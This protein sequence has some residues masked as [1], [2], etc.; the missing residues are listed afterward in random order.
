MRWLAP[1]LTI[2][3]LALV[4]CMG[5]IDPEQR[6]LCGAVAEALHPDGTQITMRGA[7]PAALGR[8][9]LRLDYTAREPDDDEA[10]PHYVICGFAGGAFDPD[11]GDLVAVDTDSGPLGEARFIYLKRFGLTD[12][13]RTVATQ[14]LPQWPF[15]LAYAAQ[16][17]VSG[18][19]LA[20]IYALLATAYA[21]IYGLVGRLN[22][23][24][25]QIAVM[26]AFW[27]IGGVGAAVAFGLENPAAGLA[28]ALVVAAGLAAGWSWV[29]GA[30]VIAP[31]HARSPRSQP[32]LVATVA[33]AVTIEEG[34]RLF[35]G[36]RDHWVPPTFSAPIGLAAAGRFVVTVTPMQIGIALAAFGAAIAVLLLLRRSRFGRNWRAFADDP[37][38]AAL[39][40]VAPGRVLAGTFLLAGL[41][42]GLAGWI[43][44][45]Y[46]GNVSAAMS[47]MLGL[48]A[49]V[50]AVVGGIGSVPGAFVGGVVIGL[51]EAFW[52][53]YFDIGMRD[54]VVY[55]ILIAIFVLRPG[56]LFG[57]SGPRP[58]DV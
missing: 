39:L 1:I 38:A 50:A 7:Q 15:S 41:M 17:V 4:G 5:S 58:R 23:A 52:S 49:L 9:G 2:V 13:G 43:M 10:R 6:L 53:A 22:L 8:Q 36:V 28:V 30:M 11:R 47:T 16:Q 25:G 29:V 40:G 26:G 55:A 51:V 46:Y 3:A 12:V 42:A 24:F 48:K 44:A 56:G 34:L 57:F 21:L 37:L 54:I 33:A 20:A 32:I 35:Q 45:V 31:L 14:G 18:V 19:P 27:A